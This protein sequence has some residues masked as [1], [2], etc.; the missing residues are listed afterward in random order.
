[1]AIKDSS[2]VRIGA[3]TTTVPLLLTRV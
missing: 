1:M 3:E 2:S